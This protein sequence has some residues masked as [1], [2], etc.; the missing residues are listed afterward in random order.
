[1]GVPAHLFD[2]DQFADG[3]YEM[4]KIV[5]LPFM[6]GTCP[7]DIGNIW[8]NDK[9]P[10][11]KDMLTLHVFMT[12][13]FLPIP[14]QYAIVTA[15]WRGFR[16]RVTTDWPHAFLRPTSDDY[17]QYN[18]SCERNFTIKQVRDFI[19]QPEGFRPA[20]TRQ[21]IQQER[22]EGRRQWMANQERLRALAVLPEPEP[23][24]DWSD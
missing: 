9:Y 2:T 14:I 8:V 23:R 1:M 6:P 12:V 4:H 3:L 15:R 21:Q 22:E 11:R 20:R 16:S 10:S 19:V 17:F 24:P 5:R 13:N 7:E 18:V